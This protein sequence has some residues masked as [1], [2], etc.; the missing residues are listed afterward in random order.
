[1]RDSNIVLR[2]AVGVQNEYCGEQQRTNGTLRSMGPYA[3]Q[4]A[5]PSRPL[6]NL[7]ENYI[8][9]FCVPWNSYTRGP[10]FT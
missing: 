4:H 8:Q 3:R 7:H 1:M 9:G 2:S 10:A 5:M 6:I